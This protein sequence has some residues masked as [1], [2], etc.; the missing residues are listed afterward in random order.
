MTNCQRILAEPKF[1]ACLFNL[2]VKENK[3]R[4]TNEQCFH[5]YTSVTSK[6]NVSLTR[7]FMKK[8]PNKNFLSWIFFLLVESSNLIFFLNVLWS[9]LRQVFNRLLCIC[10]FSKFLKIEEQSSLLKICL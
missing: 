10:I 5:K 7:M 9:L 1:W 6:T 2:Y 8:I 4:F 3:N